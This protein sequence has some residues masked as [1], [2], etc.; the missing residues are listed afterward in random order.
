MKIFK[1]SFPIHPNLD[2]VNGGVV[3]FLKFSSFNQ[4]KF[5]TN[6][7]II[8]IN[9]KCFG[10]KLSKCHFVGKY[11]FVFMLYEITNI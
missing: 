11:L 10:K 9:T 2:V 6:I 7:C 5:C 4:L 1:H 3:K 8:F